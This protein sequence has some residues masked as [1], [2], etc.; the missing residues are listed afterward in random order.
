MKIA[1]IGSTGFVGKALLQEL[2]ARGHD[3][4]AL[5]RREGQT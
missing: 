3:V 2:L 1:L 4:T 5:V